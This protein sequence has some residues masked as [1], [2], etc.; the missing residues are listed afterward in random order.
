MIPS[1]TACSGASAVCS[2]GLVSNLNYC[3]TLVCSKIIFEKRNGISPFAPGQ[4]R[5]EG[6]KEGFGTSRSSDLWAG[7]AYRCFIFCLVSHTNAQT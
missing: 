2:Y 1:P 3:G 4:V 6:R 7:K 5:K